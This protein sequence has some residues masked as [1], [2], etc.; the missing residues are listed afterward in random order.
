MLSVERSIA[1]A[2]KMAEP[3]GLNRERSRSEQELPEVVIA[4]LHE[5]GSR[6]RRQITA[7]E[8]PTMTQLPSG[9]VTFLFTDIEG[10]TKLARKHAASWEDI[11]GYIFQAVGAAFCAALVMAN[12]ANS[13]PMIPT[14]R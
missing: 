5:S 12:P 13:E 11:R 9:T 10:S 1:N 6:T 14:A 7:S 4:V 2:Q 3:R 8:G